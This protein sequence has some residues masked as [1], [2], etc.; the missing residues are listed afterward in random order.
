MTRK[1]VSWIDTYLEY[2][3]L[4][5]QQSPETFHL[6][7]GLSG[8]SAAIGRNVKLDR[9]V[10]T[11]FPNLYIVLVA[12][13]ALASKSTA[14]GMVIRILR[15]AV[16]QRKTAAIKLSPEAFIEQLCEEYEASG[17]SVILIAADEL[18]V[19]LGDE[20]VDTT[21]MKLLTKFYDSPDDFDYLTI[22][23]GS[24]EVHN[25]Y[26]SILGGSTPEW[27]K[28]SLPRKAVGGGF[29][30]RIIFISEGDEP[31]IRTAW[32][33]RTPEMTRLENDLVADLT[34]ISATTGEFTV[35][36]DAWEWYK[37]WY[38][39]VFD[40]P[41]DP[42]TRGYYGRRGDILLKVAM[43]YSL[44]RSSDLK[45]GMP[46]MIGAHNALKVV[47][48]SL[49]GIMDDVE[50][51]EI[52][53]AIERVG[54]LIAKGG[55]SIDW[56]VLLTRLSKKYIAREVSDIV[57]TMTQAGIITISSGGPRGKRILELTHKARIDYGV[58]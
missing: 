34:D 7:C 31:L 15:K 14:I 9:A 20:A 30:S 29:T 40:P 54:G 42:R 4:S 49:P 35:V 6:W 2:A 53:S 5:K 46:D 11:L 44:S 21:L 33:E 26:V 22:G 47:E 24:R 28:D 1:C 32:P 56:S 8:L 36:R 38:E 58:E 50:K 27:L 55:G 18:S 57:D 41:N 45:L 43:L 25:V 3:R 10:Y 13:S 39:E 52:G 12:E 37:H 17:N 51:T 48:A 16:P 19:F 23:R